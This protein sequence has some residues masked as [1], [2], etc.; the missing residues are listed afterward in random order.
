MTI[1]NTGGHR[2]VRDRTTASW[3]QLKKQFEN[4]FESVW[5]C[6]IGG[7][8]DCYQARLGLDERRNEMSLGFILLIVLILMLLGAIPSWPHSR[9]WGYGP[10]GG[11][12]LVLLILVVLMLMGRL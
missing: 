10:S 1:G 2:K 9:E 4:C 6:S 5:K 12:G 11:I 7:L 3:E 8:R